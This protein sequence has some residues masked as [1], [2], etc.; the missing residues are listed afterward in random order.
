MQAVG[1]VIAA[2]NTLHDSVDA[3]PPEKSQQRF[4][5]KTFRVWHTAE[6]KVSHIHLLLTNPS[7]DDFQKNTVS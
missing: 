3:H 5:S 6:V 4:G 1:A 7:D 2:L